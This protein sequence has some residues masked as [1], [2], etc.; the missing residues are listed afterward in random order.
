MCSP[1]SKV[2]ESIHKQ[3]AFSGAIRG[4][5]KGLWQSGGEQNVLKACNEPC[6]ITGNWGHKYCKLKCTLLAHQEKMQ[7]GW[8]KLLQQIQWEWVS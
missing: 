3:N 4:G 2:K 8:H 6:K 7:I 1:Y 5:Q